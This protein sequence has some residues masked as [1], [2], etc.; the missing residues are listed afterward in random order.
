MILKAIFS[1]L[2]VIK[3]ITTSI[4]MILGQLTMPKRRK[5]TEV[6]EPQKKVKTS[7]EPDTTAPTKYFY[8]EHCKSWSVYKRHA[9]R[10]DKVL[11][12]EHPN[13]PVLINSTKPRSKSF[14]VSYHDGEEVTEIWS[15]IKLGPPR[16]LKFVEDDAFM[17]LLKEKMKWKVGGLWDFIWRVRLKSYFE[18]AWSWYWSLNSSTVLNSYFTACF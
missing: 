12:A 17:E 1:I 16:R 15:G 18:R 7:D 10:L 6:A 8:I 4:I 2:I 14:E 13:I 9:T 3:S 11:S 5:K